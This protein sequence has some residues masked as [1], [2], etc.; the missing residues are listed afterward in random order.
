MKYKVDANENEVNIEVSDTKG[1]QKELLDAFQECREGRCACPTQEY[2][3][4]DTLEIEYDED[5]IS[6]KL[7]SKPNEQLDESEIKKCLEYTKG[8]AMD[9]N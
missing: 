8:K 7:T 1:K 9:E 6:L 4:L 2:S 5:S 3:K